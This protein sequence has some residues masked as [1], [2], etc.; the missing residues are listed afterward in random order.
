MEKIKIG[1]STCL[2]GEKVRYDGGHKLDRFITETL[3]RYFEYIPVCPEVEYGLPVPRESL[4]LLGDPV[5][6]RLVTSRSGIDHTGGMKRWAEKR[7]DELAHEQLCGFIFKSRS[8]SSGLKGVKVYTPSGMP[9]Y[10]GVGIF[11]AAF[12]RLNPLL[13][14]IDDGRLHDPDLRETFIDSVLVYRRWQEFLG[15]EGTAKDLV[16]LHTDLKLLILAHSPQHYKML[17]RIV[18]T[19]GSNKPE[20][21]Q[22]LWQASHGRPSPPGYEVEEHKRAPSCRRLFQG[23]AFRRREGGAAPNHR[24]L[25]EGICTS[26]SSVDPDKSLCPEIRSTISEAPVLFRPL[27]GGTH[28]EEP[29]IEDARPVRE[30]PPYWKR[31]FQHA[32][33]VDI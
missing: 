29:C 12:T 25:P 21:A 33:G 14:V 26:H 20:E 15:K 32:D 28:A 7:L 9:S 6:P 4:R 5:S 8:P 31:L 13:P 3:G 24:K 16:G 18:A 11:A 23:A 27:S 17:G 10:S 19:A 1:I 2:L 30:R 22:C